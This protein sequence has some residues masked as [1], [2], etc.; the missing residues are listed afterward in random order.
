MLKR[1][2]WSLL[3]LIIATV[4]IVLMLASN[5]PDVFRVQRSTTIAA[6]ADKIFPLIDELRA[7]QGWSPWE[8]LDPQMRKT[9]DGPA[10]GKGSIYAWDGNSQAGAGKMTI[11]ESTPSSKVVIA[12]HFLKP[13]EAHDVATFDLTPN[14]NN[15]AQT[16]VVWSLSGEMNMVSKI[17]DLL[18][19]MDKMVGKDFE[20]GLGNLKALAER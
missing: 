20:Q 18:M 17:M 16:D 9:F 6:P 2:L 14:A 15:P 3:A 10:S 12:L 13:F 1:L 7:W 8:K 19:D 11:T 5:R 4:A